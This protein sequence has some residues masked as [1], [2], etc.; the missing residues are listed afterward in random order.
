MRSR[1]KMRFRRRAFRRSRGSGTTFRWG[2]SVA[3]GTGAFG[4]QGT[5]GAFDLTPGAPSAHWQGGT[6]EPTLV[7][8]RG[9]LH[10]FL[11]GSAELPGVTDNGVTEQR[12]FAAMIYWTENDITLNP[13]QTVDVA[14]EGVLWHGFYSEK[15]RDYFTP[16]GGTPQNN[17]LANL[18]LATGTSMMVDVKARRRVRSER[19]R[20]WLSWAA[21]YQQTQTSGVIASGAG[22]G[23]L[24]WS[25]R[26]L[27][28]TSR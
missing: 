15:L 11:T 27:Y 13:L 20:L 6:A 24:S 10:P 18:S 21:V 4:I 2:A 22:A 8:I 25:L 19:V 28:R 3:Q 12:L 5:A 23:R 16:A 26:F 9:S 7:R 1:A 17:D 14:Y